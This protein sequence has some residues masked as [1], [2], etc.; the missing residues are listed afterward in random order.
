MSRV[1]CAS[2]DENLPTRGENKIELILIF[3][4]P[5]VDYASHPG[6]KKSQIYAPLD[7]CYGL[8]AVT[9]ARESCAFVS[10]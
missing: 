3:F 10:R 5:R 2:E 7:M 9:A 1:F 8:Y 6:A 4:S